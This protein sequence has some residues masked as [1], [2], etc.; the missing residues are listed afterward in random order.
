MYH[1]PE[2]VKDEFLDPDKIEKFFE[3]NMFKERFYEDYKEGE[4]SYKEIVQLIKDD[5]IEKVGE[6]IKDTDKKMMEK[7]IKY[8]LDE[9][10]IIERVKY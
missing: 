10:D 2:P 6:P 9:I 4:L 3:N 1:T 7:G 5:F 8:A